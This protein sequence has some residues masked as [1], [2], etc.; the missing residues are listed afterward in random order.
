MEITNDAK[1]VLYTLYKE[2][3]KRRHDKISK[4][5]AV[6]FPSAS[7]IHADYFPKWILADVENCLRELDCCGFLSVQY[8]DN[9]V[10]YFALN[11]FAIT[12]L[13]AQKKEIFDNV[14]SFINNFLP[15]LPN[16]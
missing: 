6:S 2:Y 12:A 16:L 9:T 10:K 4:D 15:I 1:K 13:E 8:G 7:S 5:N 14:V 11:D 3:L